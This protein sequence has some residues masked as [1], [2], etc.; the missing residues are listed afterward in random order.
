MMTQEKILQFIECFIVIQVVEDATFVQQSI[1]SCINVISDA[2]ICIIFFHFDQCFNI[3]CLGS[4]GFFL[5][6]WYTTHCAS[7]IIRFQSWSCVSF[8]YL[9]LW[10]IQNMLSS[11]SCNFPPEKEGWITDLFFFR[12]YA[13]DH[14]NGLEK[15]NWINDK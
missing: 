9:K 10:L 14:K 3:I 13:D 12:Q 7:S 6:S 5:P 15:N 8:L 2:T 1:I 4:L 11:T